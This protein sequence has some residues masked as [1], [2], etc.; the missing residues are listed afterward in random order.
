MAR[1]AETTEVLFARYG[2]RY[3]FYVT[4]VALLGTV[5]EMLTSTS[6][7]VALP[8]IMGTF[9]IGQDR[10]QWVS[11]GN[12]AGMTVGQLLC[13]W[14]IES[15]GQRKT[16]V[17]GLSIFVVALTLGGLSPNELVLILARV[18]QGVV[19]G[20]LQS[21]AMF[22]LFSVFPPAKRG[23]AMGFFSITV[24]LGPAAGPTLGGILIDQFN[25][26]YVFYMA[27]PFSIAGILFGSL[28]MPER[29]ETTKRSDFDWLGFLLLCV[30]MS[31]MLTGLSNGQREGWNSD[32]VLGLLG[33]AT[34]T[35]LA[36]IFWELRVPKP[37]VNLRVLAVG[38]YAA[39]VCVSAVFGMGHFGT[40]Y[41]IP[42]FVQTTQGFT[43]LDAGIM[44]MPGALLLGIFMPFGGYLCDRLPPRGLVI[45]GLTLFAASAY[46]MSG[47]DA[48]TSY[49]GI[50]MCVV[51]S[52][53][54]Q[55]FMNPTLNATALRSL[56]AAHLKQGTGMIN[57]FRQLGGAFGVN[58]L[59][60][61]LDRR[62]FFHGDALTSVT[63]AANT[64]TAQLLDAVQQLLA[65]AGA[66]P[67]LQSSGALH[68]LG[69]VVHAQAYSMAFRDSFLIVT[70]VF[71]LALIPAWIMGRK[72]Q[73][74]P[75][76][77]VPEP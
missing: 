18:V 64:T 4:V 19:A 75:S 9:G 29:E 36:F 76:S 72:V 24:I 27:L 13:A 20:V 48:N 42:L 66:P 77:T 16:F 55:V 45:T 51:V 2:P 46:W 41:L 15:F 44:M 14:L 12:L 71:I 35:G 69:R 47:V 67:D 53:V 8:D 52:R 25:W 1:T 21:L 73:S 50:T 37:L 10:V 5:C 26:R 33:I 34:T 54:G 60:V 40:T 62:T 30:T 65:Q 56:Q 39:A 61:S 49:L 68:F 63:T 70:L 7:N 6:V 23:M 11:T 38:P 32:F 58:L 17:G 31:C 43:P 3:R 74:P 57:F 59:S 28:F 22:T